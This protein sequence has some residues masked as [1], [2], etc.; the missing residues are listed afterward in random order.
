M[1]AEQF[2]QLK[3]FEVNFN[4]V[5]K[6]NV[7]KS[8][9]MN[10]LLLVNSIL[11]DILNYNEY[12]NQLHCPTCVFKMFK[13]LGELYFEYKNNLSVEPTEEIKRGPGRPKKI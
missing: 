9:D 6:D 4:W 13:E 3:P 7:L 2:E 11:S 8:C 10:G 12:R 1:T 5:I